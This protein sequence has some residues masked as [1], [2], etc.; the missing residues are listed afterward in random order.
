[1]IL[2]TASVGNFCMNA[3]YDTIGLNYSNLRNPDDRIARIISSSLGDA[4][5]VLNVGAGTGSYE[6]VDRKI[7]AI[8]PSMKMIRQRPSSKAT[9]LQANAEHI[10][11]QD[12]SFDASMAILTIHHWSDQ[13][14]GVLEM[15]RV[16]R[17]T[18]T[19]L[20]YEP[21]FRGFWLADYFPAL[22]SMDEEQMPQ[23]SDFENWL[24]SI[25]VSSVPIPHNCTDGFLAA[26]WRRPAAYLDKRI[27]AAMSSF[28][29]L[30]DISE[31]LERLE[32]DLQTGAWTER[33]SELLNQ[34]EYD[35]GYR[36]ITTK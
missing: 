36:L 4:R 3:L 30:K 24:G 7:T 9:V 14:K 34:E 18:I 19:F 1:M 29:A 32:R 23:L 27:R 28:Q 25:E 2:K 16:T 13:K 12:K 11:Y 21:S 5:T 8:D 6:P 10:P 33:Y 17:D 20:T 26:Y 31:G 22:I 35:C 15:R